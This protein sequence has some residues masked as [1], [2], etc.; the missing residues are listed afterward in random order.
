MIYNPVG[1]GTSSRNS[2]VT[3][4]LLFMVLWIISNYMY[5]LSL[6]YLSPSETSALFVSHPAFIYL[7]SWIYFHDAFVSARVIFSNFYSFRIK[8]L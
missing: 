4:T 7:I 8:K 1:G 5:C 2:V 6:G 3:K